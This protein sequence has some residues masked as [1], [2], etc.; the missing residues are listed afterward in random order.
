MQKFIIF[1]R[2]LTKWSGLNQ[3]ILYPDVTRDFDMSAGQVLLLYEKQV[4]CCFRCAEWARGDLFFSEA[5]RKKHLLFSFLFPFFRA[6]TGTEAFCVHVCESMQVKT[7]LWI[8]CLC[9]GPCC[10]WGRDTAS[11][12]PQVWWSA[13]VSPE[14]CSDGLHLFLSWRRRATS[15]LCA[16]TQQESMQLRS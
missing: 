7:V 12:L 13:C 5:I 10:C 2:A 4:C 9:V 3:D 15:A 6:G 8:F 11:P 1:R 16:S 14:P